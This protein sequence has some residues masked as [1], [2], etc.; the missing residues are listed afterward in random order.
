MYCNLFHMKTS[1]PDHSGGERWL[2]VPLQ[3]HLPI[4]LSLGHS[5]W[6]LQ[7]PASTADTNC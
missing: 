1:Y 5:L 7:C 6:Q 3:G 4:T 2:K